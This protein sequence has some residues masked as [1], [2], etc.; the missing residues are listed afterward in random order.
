MPA[1]FQLAQCPPGPAKYCPV[2]LAGATEDSQT[3]EA[4]GRVVGAGAGGGGGGEQGL[5]TG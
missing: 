3:Q 1:V 2:Q 4:E 5:F